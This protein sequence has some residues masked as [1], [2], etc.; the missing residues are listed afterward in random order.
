MTGCEVV[1]VNRN[2]IDSFRVGEDGCTNDGTVCTD[3]GATCRQSDGLCICTGNEPN[4]RKPTSKD[5][6]CLSSDSVRAGIGRNLNCA[7][8]PFQLIPYSHQDPATSFSDTNLDVLTSCS[9]TKAVTKFPDNPNYIDQ[10]W[11]NESYVDLKISNEKLDFKWKK[12]VPTLQGTIITLSL[13]CTLSSSSLTTKCL[14]AKI[15]GTW[16]ADA[17]SVPTKPTVTSTK[18]SKDTKTKPS[19]IKTKTTSPVTVT[20]ITTAEPKSTASARSDDDSN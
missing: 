8:R 19:Q 17:V 13:F 16:P 1:W 9:L 7:F 12:S 5:Y 10:P 14:R 3:F 4:F 20:T 18:Q 11:L 6:G 2:V 15:L